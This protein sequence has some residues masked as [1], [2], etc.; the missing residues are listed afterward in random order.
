MNVGIVANAN[1]DRRACR[2]RIVNERFGNGWIVGPVLPLPAG[3][4][5]RQQHRHRQHDEREGVQLHREHQMFREEAMAAEEEEHQ[6][7]GV[8]GQG[9]EHGQRQILHELRDDISRIPGGID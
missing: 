9:D 7:Q 5:F 8:G 3:Y 1:S 2:W 6:Q 4:I